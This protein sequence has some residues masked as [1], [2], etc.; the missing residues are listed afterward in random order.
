MKNNHLFTLAAV[1]LETIKKIETE[2]EKDESPTESVRLSLQKA[3]QTCETWTPELKSVPAADLLAVADFFMILIAQIIAQQVVNEQIFQEEERLL[4]LV[5]DILACGASHPDLVLVQLRSNYYR[6]LIYM[7]QQED[8]VDTIISHLKTVLMFQSDQLIERCR[9]IQMLDTL[10]VGCMS[11]MGQPDWKIEDQDKISEIGTQ[12]MHKMMDIY[13]SVPASYH[14]PGWDRVFVY[15]NL[16][17]HSLGLAL[18][19]FVELGQ[20]PERAKG[21][22]VRMEYLLVRLQG[23]LNHHQRLSPH[24]LECRLILELLINFLQVLRPEDA[25]LLKSLTKIGRDFAPD[26]AG[27][28]ILEYRATIA[29]FEKPDEENLELTERVEEKSSIQALTPLATPGMIEKNYVEKYPAPSLLTDE[30]KGVDKST[31]KMTT[32]HLA[33]LVPR[34]LKI[35]QKTD[36]VTEPKAGSVKSLKGQSLME[37]AEQKYSLRPRAQAAR[38]VC[39]SWLDKSSLCRI[40]DLLVVIDFLLKSVAHLIAR[41]DISADIFQQEKQLLDL[42]DR[43]LAGS[44]HHSDLTFVQFHSRYYRALCYM[45][46]QRDHI[47]DIV[48]HGNATLAFHCDTVP[49]RCKQIQA[50]DSLCLSGLAW[51][52]DL[53]LKADQYDKMLELVSDLVQTVADIYESIPASASLP[54]WNPVEMHSNLVVRTMTIV[55][56]HFKIPLYTPQTAHFYHH[57]IEKL[58]TRLQAAMNKHTHKPQEKE[59]LRVLTIVIDILRKFDKQNYPWQVQLIQVTEKFVPA[60]IGSQV[61]AHQIMIASFKKFSPRMSGTPS[62]PRIESKSVNPSAPPTKCPTPLPKL[63]D[64]KEDNHLAEDNEK[65]RRQIQ[66]VQQ[67]A[68]KQRKTLA[69][70]SKQLSKRLEKQTQEKT[71]FEQLLSTKEMELKQLTRESTQLKTELTEVQHRE[72]LLMQQQVKLSEEKRLALEKQ[73]RREVT[74]QE[75]ET[76]WKQ[77]IREQKTASESL[78]EQNRQFKTQVAD[79]QRTAKA[80]EVELKRTQTQL[81]DASKQMSRQALDR[82]CDETAKSRKIESLQNEVERLRT[83]L[84][85]E[86]TSGLQKSEFL[87]P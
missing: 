2:M 1:A 8:Q 20:A 35:I 67:A 46:Q 51:I 68:K 65:L 11:W 13:D 41:G 69:K 54:G 50:L 21:Y 16:V 74:Q 36:T 61:L 29:A 86:P 10:S 62:A 14:L 6:A 42:I 48:A 84:P 25:C 85:P 7:T 28:Q 77:Q 58:L 75:R 45:T 30:K 82:K 63:A 53:P 78:I 64:K 37:P 79:N 39:E 81:D 59:C 87:F 9:Q 17:L 12:I 19:H 22:R 70:K 4:N 32:A 40:D 66:E 38:K 33:A 5:N 27:P 72:T 3:R 55:L 34:L 76:S 80:L 44:N 24:E 26:R 43:I 71:A 60:T 15:G 56:H 47:D 49:D 31:P 73:T 52:D 18:R 83:L 23:F 57:H